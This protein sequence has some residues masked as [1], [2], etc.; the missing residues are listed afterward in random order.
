[1]SEDQKNK[2][3]DIRAVS[4]G[5]NIGEITTSLEIITM[6]LQIDSDAEIISACKSK[7]MEGITL[8]RNL[9]YTEDSKKFEI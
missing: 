5:N 9:G 2:L 6:L 8:L 3:N 4:F 1:M 7:L